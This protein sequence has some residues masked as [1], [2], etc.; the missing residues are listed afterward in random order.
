[1]MYQDTELI[2]K[3]NPFKEN[4]RESLKSIIKYIL[5]Q[6]IKNFSYRVTIVHDV[7]IR[8]I[9]QDVVYLR[10][11][12]LRYR[13]VI[14]LQF[15]IPNMFLRFCILLITLVSVSNDRTIHCLFMIVFKHLV[16]GN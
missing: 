13:T 3:L 16:K 9:A 10:R 4:T 8:R 15:V 12:W 7:C 1:M 2:R 14:R 6:Y 11:E 5:Y